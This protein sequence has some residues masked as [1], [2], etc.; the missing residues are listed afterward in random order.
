MKEILSHPWV[1]KFEK[2]FTDELSTKNASIGSNYSLQ[3]FKNTLR[4]VFY[5]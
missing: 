2:G 4:K 5:Y 1:I 3:E